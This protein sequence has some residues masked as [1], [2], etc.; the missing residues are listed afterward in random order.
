M[1]KKA[2]DS[3]FIVFILIFVVLTVGVSLYATGYKF[4]LRWPLRLNAILV[5]TGMLVVNTEPT[6]ATVYLNDQPQSE[7]LLNIWNK[8][9]AVTPAKI[10]NILPGDYNLRLEKNGYWPVQKKI[11]INPSQTTAAENINLFRNDLPIFIA[12]STSRQLLLSSSQQYLYAP[13][14]K[15]IINL[16]TEQARI[17]PDS[18][19]SGLWL[20][21]LDRLSAAGWLYDPRNESNDVNYQKIIGAEATN[22]YYEEATGRLYYQTKNSLSRLEADGKTTAILLQG[23]HYLAYEPRNDHLFV[24]ASE[25]NKLTL[26]DYDLKT[27]QAVGQII[28]PGVGQYHFVTDGRSRLSLYDEKNKTLYLI[29]PSNIAN[30]PETINHILGWVWSNDSQL[31]YYND[32]EIYYYD[33]AKN[34]STLL[35]RIGETI[36][37]LMLNPNREYLAFSTTRSLNVLDLK[38]GLATAVFTAEKISGAALDAKNN[39]L[40]FNASI[41]HNEGIYKLNLQ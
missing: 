5:K 38:T 25:P 40:Y 34:E 23:G 22:W 19:A 10:K 32:W 37:G 17:L 30:S 12:T 4:N 39:I 7:A 36:T 41:G 9:Y 18:A 15:K 28:L 24:V 31:F 20:K 29:N 8:K 35:T 27:G 6:G 1:S 21:S 11:T 33:L 3:I 26:R 2:R 16:N 13:A 14:E